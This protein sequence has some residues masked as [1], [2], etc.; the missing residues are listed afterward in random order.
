M[1]T[2]TFLGAARTVTGSKYLLEVDGTAILVD[3]GQFQGLQGAAAAQ[4]GRVSR[5]SR[6]VHAVVL[7]HAHI[8]H[9][10][11]LPRLVA[12]GFHGRIYCTAGTADLCSLVLPDAGRLQEEDA[13]LANRQRFSRHTPALPLFT[14]ADAHA[15][16]E[17]LRARRLRHA[18]RGRARPP[19]RVH[20]RRAPARLGVRAHLAHATAAARAF[21]SAATWAA[22]AGRCCPTRCRR[23]TPRRCCSN[24]PMAIGCIPMPTMRRVLERVIEETVA[25]GGRVII[26][27]FAVGRAE[28]VLYWIKR[29]EDARPPEAAARLSR[30]PDGRRAR[31]ISTRSHERE[32]DP[33][34]RAGSG[35][36]SAFSHAAVPAGRV[37]A[38]I[39][40][41]SPRRTARR[42]S[43]PPAAWRPAA[44][45]CI[46]WRRV[47]PMRATPC[48][49][50]DSRPQGTRGRRAGRGRESRQDSRRRWS[51]WRRAS[52]RSTACRRMRM[53]R[54]P[55]V[56]GDVSRRRPSRRT[57]VHG[58]PV[59]QDA[60]KSHDRADAR[61]ARPYPAARR[62]GRGAALMPT[63]DCRPV[64]HR[65]PIGLIVSS[66]STT[67]LSCS[68]MPMASPS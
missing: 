50:S 4:L 18:D 24:P 26:P 61:M 58:E 16:L 23:P 60:L 27:A 56:A 48:C 29:L 21:C 12:N 62:K 11:L 30:Q 39:A 10:G 35:E 9:S 3:C 5:P 65:A 52:R 57:C 2:L 45:C 22:T 38:R 32:L 64:R 15:A 63:S 66:R 8:D 33:D 7:T 6:V 42:S 47:C 44:G 19:G 14:E 67:P 31:S 37:A 51:R 36:V 28:E 40:R 20:Q 68:C 49:S 46:T 25:R 41:Q 59:A 34:V 55:P 43:S 17:Q 13:R 53:Q 54:D 1:A